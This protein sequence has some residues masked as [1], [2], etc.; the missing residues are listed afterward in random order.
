MPS[1]PQIPP[2][3]FF[4]LAVVTSTKAVWKS[5]AVVSGRLSVT[6]PGTSKKQRWSVGS[7]AMDMPYWQSVEQPLVRDLVGSGVGSGPVVE[8]RV[9]WRVAPVVV[10]LARTL[11]MHLWSVPVVVS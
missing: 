4:L 7:W 5:T 11:K 9:A 8:E 2:L 3:T 6:T 10:P 1:I